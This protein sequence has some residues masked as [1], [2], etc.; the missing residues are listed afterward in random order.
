MLRNV[1]FGLA[2]ALAL[3]A[4]AARAHFIWLDLKSADGGKSQARLYFSEEPEPGEADLIGKAA[5]VKVWLRKAD[6]TLAEVKLN[7]AGEAEAALVADCADA[8]ASSLEGNWDYGVYSH[9][10]KGMLLNYYAKGL[11]AD[12]A[13]NPQLARAEKLK[14]DVVPT[15]ADKKLAVQVLYDGKAVSKA[16]VQF[17]DPAGEHHD[18]TT[19]E[20]GRA[21]ISTAGGKWAVRANV[22]EADKGGERDGKKY[23]QTWHYATATFDVPGQPLA[24][25]KVETDP[26]ALEALVRARDGRAIWS[27]FPGFKADLKVRDGGK[28]TDAKVTIDAD[29]VVTLDMPE[30]EVSAWVEEQL[31]S[32][33]QHRMP[34]GEVTQGEV[35]FA[36][37]ADAHPLGRKIDLGDPSLESA[38][39]I[40][41]D[42]IMEVNR[43]AGPTMRFTI[44]VLEIE[45]N[46]ENK[47]LPRSFTMNFF[48]AKSGDLKT[49][50]G[51]FNSWQ[52]IGTFDLPKQIIEVDAHK[53]G[54]STKEIAF[55]NFELLK[56]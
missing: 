48:D 50:L 38:Y 1:L 2:C 22:I 13:K 52:R 21:E 10:P 17:V 9:G 31:N 4:P 14:L 39:R 32:M 40:K 51:Y 16:D 3:A 25:K 35:T 26:A 41:D 47:Y 46:P 43:T 20:Q 7:P 55:S 27:E 33:V 24:K 45:R 54:A 12:W 11:G 23:Q 44:S 5:K 8:A 36:D 53:G 42:V 15:L 18:L 34:D 28:A 56:K 30:S 29:G 6:G 37:E 49:S 19:D